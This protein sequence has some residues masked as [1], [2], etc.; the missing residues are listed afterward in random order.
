MVLEV[1]KH[2]A[3]NKDDALNK[4]LEELNV[5]LSEI[6]YY[7]NESESGLFKSKKYTA[8]VTTKY[9]VKEYIKNYL[10]G[11]ANEMGTT[12]NI[13]VT[14]KDGVMSCLIVTDNNAL[15]IGKDGN[16]L[17]AIQTILRQ[18]IRKFGNFDIKVNLDI[19]GYKSKR[20]RNIMYE[21]KKIA[22]EVSK[23]KVDAKLD[24]MNSYERRLVHTAI[25][26]FKHID[27][28][29]EGEEPNRCVVIKYVD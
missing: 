1:V 12:F 8:Y 20:E 27:T 18:S 13:E 6:Y 17:N 21:A 2:E 16:T 5:N 7:V 19:A 23:T 24:P 9:A 11:L 29:S 26:D 14:E 4:C 28:E 10:S 3:K 22:R 25:S 15:L